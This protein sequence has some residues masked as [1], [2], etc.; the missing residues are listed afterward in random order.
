[1]RQLSNRWLMDLAMALAF[2]AG[3]LAKIFAASV[4]L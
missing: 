1:M 2:S 4:R 3:T